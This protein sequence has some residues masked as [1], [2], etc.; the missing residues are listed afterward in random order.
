MWLPLPASW[1][2]AAF[3]AALRSH[4]ISM[5]PSDAFATTA[6]PPEAVRIGLGAPATRADLARALSTIAQLL[7]VPRA[8]AGF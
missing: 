8:A 4:D 6:T 1:S 5:T 7:D 3:L 2:R